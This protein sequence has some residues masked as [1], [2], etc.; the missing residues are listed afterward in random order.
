MAHTLK[1]SKKRLLPKDITQRTGHEIMEKIFG[2]RAMKE[3]DKLV[4]ERSED[5]EEKENN[6]SM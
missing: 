6:N 5:A 1:K 4:E 3:V 2:K